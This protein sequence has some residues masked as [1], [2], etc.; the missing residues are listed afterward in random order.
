RKL[1]GEVIRIYEDV[2]K[3]TRL[4]DSHIWNKKY[5][6]HATPDEIAKEKQRRWWAKHGRDVWELKNGDLL[7]T[8]NGILVYDSTYLGEYK[9]KRTDSGR[10]VA[11]ANI[12]YAQRNYQL[13]CFAEDRKDLESEEE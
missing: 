13:A 6:R 11:S 2:L 5:T 1:I 7:N 12:S 3:I 9:F 8:G 10:L 4:G